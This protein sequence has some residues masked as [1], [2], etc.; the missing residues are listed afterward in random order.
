MILSVR[1]VNFGSSKTGLSNVGYRLV[2]PN[3]SIQI[4]RTTDGVA[5]VL[6]GTGIYQAEISFQEGWSGS[7]VWDTG[8]ASPKYASD[9]FDVRTVDYATR[10]PTVAPGVDREKQAW[11]TKDK[12]TAMDI[13]AKTF[14]ILSEIKALHLEHSS[15][16][17]AISQRMMTRAEAAPVMES[18]AVSMKN[19][20]DIQKELLN[21]SE[22][23][24]ESQ[25]IVLEGQEILAT[26]QEV[27]DVED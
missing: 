18:L 16:L 17:A 15:I 4:E 21:I 25:S 26:L 1:N 13:L 2:N 7:I 8:E 20:G 10:F 19:V 3:G 23:M 27:P 6:A 12:K 5:E 9:A 14:E 24:M 11:S 22:G